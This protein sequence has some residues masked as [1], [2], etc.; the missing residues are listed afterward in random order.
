LTREPIFD[1]DARARYALEKGRIMGNEMIGDWRAR[2]AAWRYGRRCSDGT[3]RD[4]GTDITTRSRAEAQRDIA[5]KALRKINS[6]YRFRIIVE[7][8]SRVALA[9]IEEIANTAP[10]HSAPRLR[11]LVFIDD[12]GTVRLPTI[13]DIKKETEEFTEKR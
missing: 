6:W 3:A 9:R 8:E 1:R 10:K 13:T 12:N 5:V 11:G 7:T 4:A 2:A